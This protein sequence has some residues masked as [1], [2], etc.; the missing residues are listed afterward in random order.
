M[1][2]FILLIF[3]WVSGLLGMMLGLMKVREAHD[4]RRVP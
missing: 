4:K 3:L 1:I 2:G